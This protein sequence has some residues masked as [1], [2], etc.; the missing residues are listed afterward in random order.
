MTNIATRGSGTNG[1]AV[2]DSVLKDRAVQERYLTDRYKAVR[3]R[4]VVW[5]RRLLIGVLAV[6]TAWGVALYMLDRRAATAHERGYVQPSASAAAAAAPDV[7][8]CSAGNTRGC[9][10]GLASVISLPPAASAP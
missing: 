7:A 9:V 1:S 8:R 4:P 2:K 6:A 5:W 3:Y 10:G